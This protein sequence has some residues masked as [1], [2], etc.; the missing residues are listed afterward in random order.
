[1]KR[2]SVQAL[3][4][5]V[6]SFVVG[7]GVS[8]FALARQGALPPPASEEPSL[9]A[10]ALP[11]SVAPPPAP[12]AQ[13]A[14]ASKP[15][16]ALAPVAPIAPTAKPGEGTAAQAPDGPLVPTVATGEAATKDAP[17]VASLPPR[18]PGRYAR[19]DLKAAGLGALKIREGRLTRDEPVDFDARFRL[20]RQLGLI[21]AAED[22]RVE[23]LHVGYAADGRP[24]C[25]HVRYTGADGATVEG[26]VGLRID[27]KQVPVLPLR[28]GETGPVKPR[29]PPLL[30][31]GAPAAKPTPGAAPPHGK[32]AEPVAK[33]AGTPQPSKSATQPASK[34][35]PKPA[36]K[37]EEE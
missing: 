9:E 4:L 16:S 13:T 28:A 17:S 29:V 5:F 26:V 23:L 25:A 10:P 3:L 12:A 27:D 35:A 2:I 24:S 33:P 7:L 14:P 37:P 8:Y 18:G 11:P 31:Q 36:P 22:T 6:G 21:R 20:K 15:G 19:L 1:M 32:P 30:P 34:A